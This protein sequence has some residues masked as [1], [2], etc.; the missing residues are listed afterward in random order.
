MS[1]I[2]PFHPSEIEQVSGLLTQEEIITIRSR[3][4]VEV[5]CG[6]RVWRIGR[7]TGDSLLHCWTRD[8]DGRWRRFIYNTIHVQKPS[9]TT[10]TISARMGLLYIGCISQHTIE[11]VVDLEG[12]TW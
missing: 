5:K 10:L 11:V 9:I 1:T 2:T 3:G 7:T 4:Y 6:Q 8:M 12:N